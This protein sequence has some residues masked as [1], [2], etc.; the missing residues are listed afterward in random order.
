MFLV[1]GQHFCNSHQLFDE[2]LKFK[3]KS[4]FELS[5]WYIKNV[6]LYEVR[7]PFIEELKSEIDVI[8]LDLFKLQ[9]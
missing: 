2:G 4:M 6:H 7:Y 1:I 9:S 8:L 3:I 5:N